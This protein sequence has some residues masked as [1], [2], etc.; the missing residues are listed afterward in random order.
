MN[1]NTSNN[2][3]TSKF[4]TVSI[5]GVELML[6]TLS[7]QRVRL[8]GKMNMLLQIA[9]FVLFNLHGFFFILWR[10]EKKLLNREKITNE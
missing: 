9:F 4:F 6:D 1:E 5:D 7:T 3:S 8:P 2:N 10:A